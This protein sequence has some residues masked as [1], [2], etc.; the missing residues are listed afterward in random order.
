ME[1]LT[2]SSATNY[3]KIKGKN[4]KLMI[5]CKNVIAASFK[6]IRKKYRGFYKNIRAKIN[7]F[8]SYL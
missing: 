4:C 8:E 5:Y 6:L 7:K 3:Y 2:D 1:I